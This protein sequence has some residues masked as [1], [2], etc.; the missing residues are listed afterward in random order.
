VRDDIDC[1]TDPVNDRKIGDRRPA[2]HPGGFNGRIRGRQ[3]VVS[4][5]SSAMHSVVGQQL[6]KWRLASGLLTIVLGAFVLA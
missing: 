5:T 2:R 4:A 6:W 3:D 1:Q